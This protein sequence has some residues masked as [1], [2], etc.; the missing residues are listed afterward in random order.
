MVLSELVPGQKI[1]H[2]EFGD[3]VIIETPRDSYVRVFFKDGERHVQ[4]SSIQVGL[5]REEL[6]IA[7]V[8]GDSQ[9]LK[10][11]WLAYE[12]VALPLMESAAALTAAKIDVLPHQIVLVHRLA[13]ASPRRFLVADEVGLGKTIETALAL[14]ELESRGELKRAL[15]IVPAGLVNNWHRELNEVFN[16]N[17]EVFGSEGDVTDRK[18]NAFLKHDRLIAS[19]DTM[20][21]PERIQRLLEAPLWDLV[22]FDEAHTT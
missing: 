17:F 20:K 18:S 7:G 11:A 5:T 9:R 16:L 22:V 10:Q 13:T 15:M 6:I 4:I 2:L 14:R 8:R 19:I 21:R 12:A 1:Q 3:G